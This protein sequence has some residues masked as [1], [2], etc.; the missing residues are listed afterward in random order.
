[1]MDAYTEY[2]KYRKYYHLIIQLFY[3]LILSFTTM[4]ILLQMGNS[5]LVRWGVCMPTSCKPNDIIIFLSK[6]TGR[7]NVQINKNACYAN[8]RMEIRTIDIVYG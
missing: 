3:L 4:S 2:L 7:K 8:D 6:A 5:T 1:M